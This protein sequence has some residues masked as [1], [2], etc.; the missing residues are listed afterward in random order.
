MN[1]DLKK[2]SNISTLSKKLLIS[3]SDLNININKYPQNNTLHNNYSKDERY[4]TQRLKSKYELLY[5]LSEIKDIKNSI[6]SDDDNNNIYDTCLRKEFLFY[7]KNKKYDILNK[8]NYN[9]IEGY[10]EN[11]FNNMVA[12]SEVLYKEQYSKQIPINPFSIMNKSYGIME[13]LVNK[14][15]LKQHNYEV[16]GK[17][18]SIRETMDIEIF[19]DYDLKN[20]FINELDLQLLSDPNINSDLIINKKK[21][22]KD[23]KEKDTNKVKLEYNSKASKERVISYELIDKIVS[24][25]AP[26]DNNL[27]LENRDL[28]LKNLFSNKDQIN[29]SEL[30][31]KENVMVED[32]YD[33]V[34]LF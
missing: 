20:L 19:E 22:L 14:T 32:N 31:L 27:I 25:A 11:D 5:L 1:D 24:F 7:K 3:L 9:D 15:K 29:N 34:K 18:D 10:L 26:E 8:I 21:I 13:T 17:S 6:Y 30:I 28:I 12:N 33:D 16:L 4:Y 2:I 23:K